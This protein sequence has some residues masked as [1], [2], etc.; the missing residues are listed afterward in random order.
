[1]T[2]A[3]ERHLIF[4][5]RLATYGIPPPTREYR[6]AIQRR[7][8]FDY[9]WPAQKLAV[10]IEG[11]AFS[12]GRHTSGVGFR[13]DIEKYNTAARLGWTVL[14]FLP[15]NIGQTDTYEMILALLTRRAVE[16]GSDD[17]N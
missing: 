15:E 6:F 2:T 10:E 14:R 8:R 9:C 16:Q 12:G 13:N 11:G 4:A 1:M 7:W 5:N 3:E 17:A